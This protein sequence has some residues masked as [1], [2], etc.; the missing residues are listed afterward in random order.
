M[1]PGVLPYTNAANSPRCFLGSSR[2]KTGTLASVANCKPALSVTTAIA[3]SSSALAMKLAPCVLIPGIATKRSPGRRS[4]VFMLMPVIE[5]N[6]LAEYSKPKCL[7][8]SSRETGTTCSGLRIGGMDCLI[9][10]I[11]SLSLTSLI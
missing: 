10:M 4:P 7:A 8:K 6:D 5:T 1:F 3:P 9:S 2:T 11:T